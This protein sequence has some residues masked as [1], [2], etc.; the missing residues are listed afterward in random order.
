MTVTFYCHTCRYDTPKHN[1]KEVELQ[2]IETI[3]LN[4]ALD[5][6][7]N[8]PD[9]VIYIMNRADEDDD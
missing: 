9:H 8:Y 7:K 2:L 6:I 3:C 5:H 1:L 4:D